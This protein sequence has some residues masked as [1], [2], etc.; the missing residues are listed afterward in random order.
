MQQN[1]RIA[2]G[3]IGNGRQSEH[4]R[5]RCDGET[6]RRHRR[7]VSPGCRL[8]GYETNFTDTRTSHHIARHRC[9]TARDA[10]SDSARR[11]ARCRNDER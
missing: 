11:L 6:G 1:G 8:A 2:E 3:L 9:G 5:C 7:A 10:V 4:R